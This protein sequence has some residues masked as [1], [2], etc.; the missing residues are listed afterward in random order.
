M[1]CAYASMGSKESA[2]TCLDAAM[3][4]GFDDFAALRADPDLEPLRGPELDKLLG[5]YDGVMQKVFGKKKKPRSG[6]EP[7]FLGF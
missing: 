3:E 4:N 5:K 2:Y 6:T 1:A 7:I